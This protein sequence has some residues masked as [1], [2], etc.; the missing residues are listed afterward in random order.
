MIVKIGGYDLTS[1]AL[2][3]AYEVNNIEEYTEWVDARGITHR[4]LIRTKVQGSFDVMFKDINVF[5]L[6]VSTLRLNKKQTNTYECEL[7]CNNTNTSKICDCFVD[8]K[9]VRSQDGI[10]NDRFEPF[11]I[12][13]KEK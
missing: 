3:G 8:F 13:I 9:P 4:D 11:T 5:D 2:V 10:G 7:M 6:F 12:E 1:I